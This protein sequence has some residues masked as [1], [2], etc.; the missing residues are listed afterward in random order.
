MSLHFSRRLRL[1]WVLALFGPASLVISQPTQP[2]E[3][4]IYAPTKIRVG[5]PADAYAYADSGLPVTLSIVSGTELASLA[6]GVLTA[7]KPGFVVLRATQEGDAD[8]LPAEPKE[9]TLFVARSAAEAVLAANEGLTLQHSP[10]GDPLAPHLYTV[11]FWART[12]RVYLV[13]ETADLALG[14]W[15]PLPLLLIGAERLSEPQRFNSSDPGD[16]GLY[17]V[18]PELLRFASSGDRQFV[19][20]RGFDGLLDPRL[21]DHDRDGV[22]NYDETTITQTNPFAYPDEDLADSEPDGLPDAWE[23][24][25]LGTT[26]RGPADTDS[27]GRAY[28]DLY[29]GEKRDTD[30]DG[31][32]DDWE[33]FRCGG[34]LAEG[35]FDTRE[36]KS[37]LARFREDRVKLASPRYGAQFFKYDRF[38]PGNAFDLEPE[39]A[40]KVYLLGSQGGSMIVTYSDATYADIASVRV[41]PSN[42]RYGVPENPAPGQPPDLATHYADYTGE[43]LGGARVYAYSATPATGTH[44][45]RDL[46][47]SLDGRPLERVSLPSGQLRLRRAPLAITSLPLTALG[48]DAFPILLRDFPYDSPVFPEF[49]GDNSVIS[50]GMIAPELKGGPLVGFPRLADSFFASR[51]RDSGHRFAGWYSH[52]DAFGF[53]LPR[54][55][56]PSVDYGPLSGLR[57]LDDFFPHRNDVGTRAVPVLRPSSHAFTAELHLRLDYD[58]ATT[59]LYFENDDD[60]WVFI[61]GKLVLDLGGRVSTR[62]TGISLANMRETVRNREGANSTFLS[63][64]T[65]SCVVDIF[66]AER[67]TGQATLTVQANTPL[68]PIYVYQVAAEADLP[69]PLAYS[70]TQAPPGM[71][72]DSQS[73]RVLWDYLARNRDADPANDIAAGSYPVTISVSDSRGYTVTQ[74]FVLTVQLPATP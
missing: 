64:A 63:A 10:S 70:L 71:M 58:L 3:I 13:E 16:G 2:Q 15:R 65:G 62:T 31:L 25:R 57:D 33:R 61:N 49:G 51:P 11:D 18:P 36:G 56:T 8:Y 48:P 68:H 40:L 22:C 14:P 60:L 5:A 43:W 53:N 37:N 69:T 39:N 27:A 67:A 45:A 52:P 44:V 21:G 30:A 35:P 1:W 6:D 50:Y 23:R 46:L 28:A 73:G 74:S 47:R 7:L 34:S 19:R 29:A 4:T 42:R 54:V 20:I 66:Y 26:A 41:W 17:S 24:Y 9:H 59:S 12:G 32:P 38:R 55:N 72:I